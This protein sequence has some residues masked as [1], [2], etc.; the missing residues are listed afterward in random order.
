MSFGATNER[1]EPSDASRPQAK[2]G[3]PP[4]AAPEE[5]F[6]TE[7]TEDTDKEARILSLSLVFSVFSVVSVLRRLFYACRE[8]VR[9]FAEDKNLTQGSRRDTEGTRGTKVTNNRP[10]A[11]CIWPRFLFC[12]LHIL[13]ELCGEVFFGCGQRLRC[14][15]FSFF[16]HR[17]LLYPFLG[18]ALVAAMAAELP[19]GS[20]ANP[21]PIHFVFRPIDFSLDS[22]E[23]PERHAPE[24]MEGGVA[25]FDYDNDGYL[26]IFFANGADITTLQKSS[27]R[28]RNRLFHNN[29]DGTFTDVTEKAGLAGTGY[30]TG[31]AIGDYDNDGFEDIFVGGV[32]RNT[33]YHNNGDGTFTDVTEKAGLAHLDKEYGPLWSVGG[34][35]VDVNNDGLLD[36]FV[37]NYLSWD[38]TK[39]PDCRYNGKP[40][41]CHPKFYRELPNQLFLN[42]GDGTFVDV[43]AESGIRSHP[44]KAMGVGVADYDSDGWPDIFVSNDK[45]FNF[46]FHNKGNGKFEEV[47]FEAGVALSEHGSLISNMGVDFRDFNNDGLP[48]IA[49]VALTGESFPLYQNTGKGDFT[50]VTAESG[51]TWL[52]NPMSG[53]SPNI[54]DFD[55]D[56]WKD[57]FVSRGDVQSPMMADKLHVFQPNTV[58]RNLGN[59]R[60]SALTEEA[61]FAAQPPQRHRGSAFGDFNHDGKLDLV[62]T[63]LSAPAEIWMNDSPGS[64]HWLE[65]KLE[66]TKSNRDAIGARIRI[67]AGGHAQVNHVSTACGYASSSAGPVHFGLGP[68][69]TVDEIEIRWPSGTTQVLKNV[70]ADQILRV[71]EPR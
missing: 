35:W 30:D 9:C 58:F 34:A 21:S 61:G 52:A 63:A 65:L 51:M 22:C 38:V 12:R 27:P 10:R 13:C 20:Q 25:V 19:A 71:K 18:A 55:N 17:P 5:D 8:E 33:L 64:N 39:E 14:V 1:D 66:G 46:L 68:A 69:K 23:T 53:Y 3:A 44:G 43:S 15:K 7:F 24:T 47:A 26:D 40:E 60:W 49:T 4:P 62:V 28:Y 29:G 54:A 67:S 45:L 2:E 59:G 56:G 6:T 48:D 31:V 16:K 41:Y 37:A 70:P 50:E 57:I 36:L 32:H 11:C 42:K